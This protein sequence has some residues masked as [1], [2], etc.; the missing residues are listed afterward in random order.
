MQFFFLK[1]LWRLLKDGHLPVKLHSSVPRVSDSANECEPGC[2]K[3]RNSRKNPSI[4]ILMISSC[5]D[6]YDYCDSQDSQVH[7]NRKNRR[8]S[9]VFTC[10]GVKFMTQKF[11]HLKFVLEV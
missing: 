4:G 3:N 2:P 11:Y 6:S 10:N 9:V 7:T 5:W 1:G 8:L